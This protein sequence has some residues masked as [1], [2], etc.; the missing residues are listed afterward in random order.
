MPL[1]QK[2]ENMQEVLIFQAAT[3]LNNTILMIN[4]KVSL[5]KEATK[6]RLL[7]TETFKGLH[8]KICTTDHKQSNL[9][10]HTCKPTSHIGSDG[11]QSR[12]AVNGPSYRTPHKLLSGDQLQVSSH[13]GDFS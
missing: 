5:F 7:Q 13:R 6:P 4:F 10:H 3:C 9:Q 2:Q 1:N 11:R 8:H 12:R